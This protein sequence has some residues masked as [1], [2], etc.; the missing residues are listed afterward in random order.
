MTIRT[1]LEKLAFLGGGNMGRALIGGL[2]QQGTRPEAIAVGEAYEPSRAALAKDLGVT[3][4]ADNA[5]AVA[6]AT[7][8]VLAVKPQDAGAVLAPLAPAL[9][10]THPLL[11]SVCAGLKVATLESWAGSRIAV[12]RTMPNRPAFVGAG[13]TGLFA[14]PSVGATDRSR[15]EAVMRAAGEVVWV[16]DES[17]IDAVT[18]LSGSGPA[19]F[20]YFAELMAQA[21]VDLGL[22]AEVARRLAVA[23][24]H[25]AGML[26]HS[27]DGDLARLR[28][29]VTSKGGTTE[30]ALKV[31]IAA[32]LRGIVGRAMDAAARRG[33]ELATQFGDKK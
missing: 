6:N 4:T 7:I 3:A 25:G 19:Y 2:L 20:F 27:S 15:A 21:G 31:M 8:I 24:L 33:V 30:A 17:H 12:V 16:S 5:A 11:I 22:D 26:A 28:A 13:A 10:K 23:T 9:Q 29:E 18:A 1:Q 32:D 14:P